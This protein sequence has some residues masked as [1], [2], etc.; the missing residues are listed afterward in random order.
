MKKR[1][2]ISILLAALLALC[3]FAL[4][5]C[6]EACE[7]QYTSEVTK[8]AT[9]DTEGTVRYTCALC[10]DSYTENIRAKGHTY[11]SV[12]TAPT[13]TED[14]YTTYTCH[15]GDSY[16]NI[17]ANALGHTEVIDEAVAPTCTA[18][19]LTEGKHC[20]VCG[21]VLV[22]Q[23]VIEK[24]DHNY[25]LNYSY[26]STHHYYECECSARKG[27]EEHISSGPA[28]LTE[29][30]VCT[31][32]NC[33][34]SVASGVVFNNLTVEGTNVYGVV[35][36]EVTYFSFLNEISVFGE[37]EYIVS[38]TITGTGYLPAKMI[39][40]L[41]GNNTVY[42]IEMINGVPTTTYTVVIRRKPIYTVTFNAAGGMNVVPVE[43]EEGTFITAPTTER[44][45]Y[46]FVG[47]DYDFENAVTS[48]ITVSAIWQA[49]TD[50]KYKVEYYL[51][52]VEK[53]G[54]E[55]KESVELCGT[56]DTTATA[57]IKSFE[58]F[59]YNSYL[60]STSGNINGD[61]SRVLKVYYTRNMYTI[62]A[63]ASDTKGGS[64]TAGG[65]YPYGSEITLSAMLNVGYTFFGYFIGDDVLCE[66]NDYTFAVS[67]DINIIAKFEANTN[68]KYKVEY[69]L[70]NVEKNG[71]ELKETA[72][73]CGTTNTTAYAEIKVLEHFTYNE[74]NSVISGNIDGDGKRVLKVYYTRNMYTVS[75]ANTERGNAIGTGSYAYGAVGIKVSAIE[76]LGCKFIGWYGNGDLLSNELTYVFT[77]E[78]NV[79][80]RFAPIPDMENFNFTSTKNECTITEI[81]DKSLTQIIIPDFVTSIGSSA[82]QDCNAIKSIVIPESVASIGDSAFSGCSSLESITIPFVGASEEATGYKSHFGYIFGYSK[83][84]SGS[85]D[86]HYY[87]SS[88]AYYYTYYIPASLK[89]VV[90]SDNI[91]SIGEDAFNYC[92]G[93][94][95]IVIPDSVTSI[96][97]D[98]F[99]YC[100][101]LTSVTI[102]NGVTSIGER[103]FYSCDSLTSVV[104]PDSVT[105][106]GKYAFNYCAN[107]TSVYITDIAGWCNISFGNGSANPLNYAKNLYL[108][109]ELVT[110]LVIPDSVTSIGKYAF[111][112]CRSF[113]SVVIP[114]SVT[115]IGEYAFAGCS[116]L[117]SITIP[118]S[119]PYIS[120][121]AFNYCTSLTSITIPDSVTNIGS[122]VFDHCYGLTSIVIPDSVTII[123]S[124][125]FNYCTG[126]T[127]IVI[128]DSV[129]SI[130]KY[131]FNYC[132]GLTS[133]VIPDSV[134]NIGRYAFDGC[135]KLVE[136]INKSSLNITTG[137]DG[138]YAKEV[139]TGKSKVVNYNDYLFYTYNGVNYLLGYV[140]N[141]TELTLPESYNGESYEIYMYAFYSCDSLT[142]IVIP[143]S[144]TSI[145]DDAFSGCASLTSIHITD[146]AAWCNIWFGN[147]SANPLYYAKHLYL[148]GELVTELVIPDSV[149]SIGKYAFSG[150]DSLTSVVIPDSIKRIDDYAFSSCD[151]LTSVTIGN[152]VTSIGFNAFSGCYKLVEVINKSSLNITAGSDGYGYAGY[153]AIEVHTGESKIVNYNDYLFYT[154]NGV[155]YLFGY[156]GNDTELIL[157]E[158]YNGENYEIYNYAFYSCTS[159]TSIT[160]PDSVTSIG[161]W[162]FYSCD[163][164][165]SIVIPES[166]TSIGRYAFSG[167]DSLTSVVIPDS[168]TSI[169]EYAFS[170]CDSLTSVVI[171]DSVTSIGEYAFSS[172]DSLTICCEATSQP[173]GW[174][175]N[176]NYSSCPVVWGWEV[177]GENPGEGS[178]DGIDKEN[179]L[180]IKQAIALGGQYV[181]TSNSSNFT[182]GKYY[183]TG[184]ITQISNSTRGDMY[185]TDEE[186]NSLYIYGLYSA[187]GTVRYDAMSDKPIVGDTI[188]VY[189]IVGAYGQTIEMKNVWLV[190]GKTGHDHVYSDATCAA[191]R[192]CITCGKTDG[193]ALGHIDENNDGICDREECGLNS[194]VTE[195]TESMSVA[196]TTGILASDGK[197]ISWG[198]GIFQLMVEQHESS[199]KIRT[200]DSDHFR[201]YSASRLTITAY[202]G[203]SIS[204]VVITVTDSKY[205]SYLV[206]SITNAGYT[207]TSNGNVV[208]I[209]VPDKNSIV[210]IA[211]AQIRF[212]K[213][214]VTT[215]S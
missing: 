86:S 187:D 14:G 214:E 120:S 94:T 128:P 93:L 22:E 197:S 198:A 56:T 138:Y 212:N 115:S 126:L 161:N 8:E 137:S 18:T 98:A 172:C 140:G 69:Y 102:G 142:S 136:V 144:V 13:C 59:A 182:T 143:D 129:T 185:I 122:Y 211:S 183:V 193:D 175:S 99:F 164:L 203:A 34:M 67:G 104:I 9:C 27:E 163:S 176:W 156:T 177:S 179:T 62:T 145:G 68:T 106:I 101:N 75:N 107:L 168:V 5:S 89:T 204:K 16:V 213:V 123:G 19:G 71:Y 41:P 2:W 64:V 57:E 11:N 111:Y 54:Y 25:S 146:I 20:S 6:G 100:N 46:T 162:A 159:L 87:D 151:N 147:N 52:N 131:A 209:T 148:N 81:K 118:D 174:D 79:E 85:N 154:Y 127:S 97:E 173:S 58:H 38:T 112:G 149:T 130:G 73:L 88:T 117:T 3:V 24:S 33:V 208:T 80:A 63:S 30:E 45:G 47:W 113:T 190:D 26:N 83:S 167:C 51:E 32:C 150:C 77:V 207:A 72:E 17:T 1:I 49:N 215:L 166:V 124:Y 29:N 116:S 141:D 50:T 108:N 170:S 192:T 119:V 66:T 158:N 53:N 60:G 7:H 44:I 184:V 191:G 160:I 180:T 189:G 171:P 181:N 43:A 135:Y 65:R 96:D 125:A 39:D 78:K 155:N 12:P 205:V 152:S 133:V 110:E 165:T 199:T 4:C 23:T 91:T 200:S 195:R 169:G 28:T 55:F 114:N 95:S 35:S 40:L 76:F 153:Y 90:L 61:G 82:F 194:N 70:E 21:D 105:S 157:P 201:F 109:G 121:Y 134:T 15:C 31:V 210:I 139:H 48:N 84:S 188:T 132:T 186:G 103:A 178:G 42:V 10:A 37:A 74:A 202:S 36:N 196:A 92:T 206:T